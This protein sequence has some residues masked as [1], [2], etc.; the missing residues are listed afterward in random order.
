MKVI[1]L[2]AKMKKM[3][4]SEL[5]KALGAVT[6]KGDVGF[7]QHVYFSKQ[8]YAE[9]RAYMLASECKIAGCKKPT[10]H[11][12]CAVEVSLMNLGPSSLYEEA[13]KPGYVLIDTRAIRVAEA[14]N[15]K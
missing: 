15:A 11:I 9:L 7:P 8:D 2:T 13:L 3:Y 12:K 4:A 6:L 10:K 5:L 1:K 14:K